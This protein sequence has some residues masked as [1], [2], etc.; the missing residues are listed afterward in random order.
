MLQ[1]V[2]LYPK[3]NYLLHVGLSNGMEGEFDVSPWL[4][5]GIFRELKDYDYFRKVRITFGGIAWPNEQDFSADTI[6]YEMHP[7]KDF[8]KS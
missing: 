2:K 8:A 6:E 4:E 1:V 3:G 7:M 5:M